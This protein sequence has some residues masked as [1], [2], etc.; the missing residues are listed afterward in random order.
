MDSRRSKK[1]KGRIELQ[2][3]NKHQKISKEQTDR[4]EEI[5]LRILTSK[6]GSNKE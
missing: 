2:G 1:T 6:H 5:N 4:E 3:N